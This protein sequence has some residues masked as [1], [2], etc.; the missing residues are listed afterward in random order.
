MSEF[1]QSAASW[2]M[3][4]CVLIFVSIIV[5]YLLY[6]NQI[7]FIAQQAMASDFAL[8]DFLERQGETRKRLFALDNIPADGTTIKKHNAFNNLAFF[9]FRSGSE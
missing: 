4:T 3:R 9:I 5:E 1:L 7:S 6:Y 8:R 2:K